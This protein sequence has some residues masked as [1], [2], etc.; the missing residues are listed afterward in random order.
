MTDGS[1]CTSTY[2]DDVSVDEDGLYTGLIVDGRPGLLRSSFTISVRSEQ[3][4]AIAERDLVEN[5]ALWPNPVEDLIGLSFN[6]LNNASL[7]LTIFDL[8]GRVVRSTNTVVNTGQ[9]DQRIHVA[10]LEAG[11]YLLQITNGEQR[12]SRRFVKR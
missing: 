5:V 10:D 7:S 9:N 1:G 11:M 12:S 6:S 8:N 4:T 3:P 2:C